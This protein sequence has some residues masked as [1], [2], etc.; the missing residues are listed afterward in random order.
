LEARWVEYITGPAM[1]EPDIRIKA[2]E[3]GFCKRHYEMT[4]AQRNRLAV[5][6]ML[7]TRLEW[8]ASHKPEQKPAPLFGKAKAEG[9]GCFVCEIAD[10]EFARILQ[11]VAVVW[12]REPDFRQLYE[13]QAFVCAHDAPQVMAAA[14]QMLRGAE[15]SAFLE[16]TAAL[17][18]KRLAALKADIDAFCKLY[19][20]RS[21]ENREVAGNVSSAIGNAID[22]LVGE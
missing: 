12:A 4:L 13:R 16:V 19:D 15:L 17:S 18:G 21:A 20:Y 14:R 2:N 3:T 5:A 6:L 7:Q 11:N 9:P 1:M 22:Y 10:K 8:L